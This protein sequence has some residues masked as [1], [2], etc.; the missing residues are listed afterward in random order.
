MV[1][2]LGGSVAYHAD[3]LR[4]VLCA[5]CLTT[6]DECRALGDGIRFICLDHEPPLPL[7]VGGQ[8]TPRSPPPSNDVFEYRAE[9]KHE[10]GKLCECGAF[11]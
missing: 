4:C 5:R 8:R 3:C 9:V 7:N 11:K 1:R 6:G 2:L 10:G